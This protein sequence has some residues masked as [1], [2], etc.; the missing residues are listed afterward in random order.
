MPSDDL[1]ELT[2]Q[3]VAMPGDTNPDGDIFGGWLLSQMDLA[4]AV[5]AKKTAQ[6]RVVTV[7]MDSMSFHHPVHVGDLIRCYAKLERIGN[8]S[9][10]IHVQAWVIDQLNDGKKKVTEGTFT[11]VSIGEDGRPKP[12]QP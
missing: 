11:F 6:G 9:L 7:A 10:K 12:V 8:T 2:I 1:G 4:G 5:L 3:T